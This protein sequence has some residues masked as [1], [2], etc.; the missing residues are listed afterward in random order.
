MP[1]AG[2]N[3]NAEQVDRDPIDARSAEAG[4]HVPD[5]VA[6]EY[7]A[8]REIAVFKYLTGTVGLKEFRDRHVPLI[9]KEPHLGTIWSMA[10]EG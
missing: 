10:V 8:R 1:P 7:D 6:L 4:S 9:N 3:Q 5:R 2:N